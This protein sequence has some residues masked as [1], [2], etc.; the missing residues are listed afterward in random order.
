MPP[1]QLATTPIVV[2]QSKGTSQMLQQHDLISGWFWPCQISFKLT[3]WNASRVY[4]RVGLGTLKFL[5]ILFYL[6][7]LFIA[8]LRDVD[9]R[10]LLPVLDYMMSYDST[11]DE[12]MNADDWA[13]FVH[14]GRRFLKTQVH[15][16][17]ILIIKKKQLK[18]SESNAADFCSSLRKLAE[19]KQTSTT[20]AAKIH[21]IISSLW[22]LHYFLIL[23]KTTTLKQKTMHSVEVC[24]K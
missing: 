7:V 18:K 24:C 3:R 22:F 20:D 23:N 2:V 14:L 19:K 13:I 21:Q 1:S 17:N 11:H 16:R 4:S 15:W 5:I 12:T 10:S 6:Q 9:S 8:T